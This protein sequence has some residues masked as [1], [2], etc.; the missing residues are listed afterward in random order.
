MHMHG[1]G[2]RTLRYCAGFYNFWI[3]I[4]YY[5]V[6][7]DTKRDLVMVDLQETIVNPHLVQTAFVLHLARL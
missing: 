4:K 5:R 2:C 1:C 7:P 3:G 6:V